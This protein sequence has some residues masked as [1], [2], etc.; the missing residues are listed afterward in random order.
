MLPMEI[1][2]V[3]L[4]VESGDDDASPISRWRRRIED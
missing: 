1:Q 3:A 2:D 4:L